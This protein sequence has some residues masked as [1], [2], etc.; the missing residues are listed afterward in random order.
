MTRPLKPGINGYIL[1]V[2]FLDNRKVRRIKDACGA[3]AIGCLIYLLG[4]IGTH[5][6]KAVFRFY[7]F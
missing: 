7:R 1:D 5:S 2:D 4:N 3:Q 6:T